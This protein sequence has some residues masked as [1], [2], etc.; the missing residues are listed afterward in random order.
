MDASLVDVLRAQCFQWLRERFSDVYVNHR[1]VIVVPFETTAVFVAVEAKMAATG[2]VNISSPVLVN[3][4]LTPELAK[5]VALN[6]GNFLYGALSLYDE[7]GPVVSLEFDYSLF[8][9]LVNQT[10]L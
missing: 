1:N 3:L 10:V 5:Y 8:G 9:E 4:A 6:G 7:G 2:R